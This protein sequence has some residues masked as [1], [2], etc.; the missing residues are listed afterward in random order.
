MFS[1]LRELLSSFGARTPESVPPTPRQILDAEIAA[2]EERVRTDTSI[3]DSLEDRAMR[4][5]REGREDT[6]QRIFAELSMLQERLAAEEVVLR[7]FREQRANW[8][9]ASSQ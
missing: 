6:A 9:V 5:V 4:A 1:R 7:E 2:S 8:E 3:L